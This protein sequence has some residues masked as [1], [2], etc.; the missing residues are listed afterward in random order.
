[1]SIEEPEAETKVNKNDTPLRPISDSCRGKHVLGF[2]KGVPANAK[3][4]SVA[5]ESGSEEKRQS[6]DWYHTVREED[7]PH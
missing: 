7:P 4:V 6:D 2:T 1:M 3:F 5:S